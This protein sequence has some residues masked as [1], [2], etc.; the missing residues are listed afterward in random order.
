MSLVGRLEDLG[1]GEILQIVALS[2]KSGILHIKSQKREG[3]I[4]FYKGKVVTAYSDAYR[5]NLGEILIHKGYVTPD[6]LK[7]ALE[8]QKTSEK[9][10][11]LGWI[12]INNFNIPKE[13][14]EEC[15]TELIEKSVFSLFYWHEGEFRFELTDDIT[16]DDLTID[17]LQ[18]DLPKAKGLNPQFLAMEGSRLV[19]EGQIETVIKEPEKIEDSSIETPPVEEPLQ[20]PIIL[21]IDDNTFFLNITKKLLEQKYEVETIDN[22]DKAYSKYSSLKNEG[23]R[24]FSIVSI[25]IPK[26]DGSGILGGLDII[27]KMADEGES[28]IIAICEYSLPEIE[29]KLRA[30]KINIIKKPK[31][32]VLTKENITEQMGL[33]I[34]ALEATIKELDASPVQ[35]PQIT[36]WDKELKEEFEIKEEQS[37][38]ITTPGLTILKSMIAELGQVTSGNEIILLILRLA[39]EIMPRGVLFAIKTDTMQGLGQFG[40]ERFIDQPL[41]VVRNLTISLKGFFK[42]VIN[43]NM[44]YKGTPLEDENFDF[45]LNKLGGQR[46]TEVFFAPIISG[47]KVVALFYGDNL[48]DKEPIRDTDAL[49]IFLTQ[50]GIT[51]E[52]LLLEKKAKGDFN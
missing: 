14:I 20:K 33:F 37:K 46:P 30:K 7:K 16:E 27:E 50:A 28:N 21:I 43:A 13:K 6:I 40:L 11:K 29:E 47:G 26:P 8:Y 12:L 9:K 42:E 19:D 17:L 25:F 15:V 39:S 22:I 23:K 41:K 5:V 10:Y 4:Y 32:G 51:M 36:H 48:P 3:K 45:L 49:E 52:R 1:L 35:K 18:Y 31:R 44:P 24:V 2:G 34:K 38:I